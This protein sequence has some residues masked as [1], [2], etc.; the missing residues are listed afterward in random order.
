MYLISWASELGKPEDATA[1]AVRAGLDVSDYRGWPRFCRADDDDHP[2]TMAARALRR[3]LDS[4]GVKA[5]E[6]GAVIYTG[7]SRDYPASWSVATEVVQLIGGSCIG[8]D[9]TFGCLGLLIG[10]DLARAWL[11]RARLVAVVTAERWA[12]TVDRGAAENV[13]IWAHADGAAAVVCSSEG[14]RLRLLDTEY[15]ARPEM[16]GTVFIK[17]GG[18]RYPTPPP[19][20]SPHTRQLR[21][22]RLGDLFAKYTESLERVVRTVVRR[23][24]AADFGLVCN[25]ISP[26]VVRELERRVLDGRGAIPRTGD[27][28]GHV[29]GADLVLGIEA[30]ESAGALAG[31]LVV[32]SSSPYSYAAAALRVV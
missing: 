4:A 5:S 3:A 18:T 2:S 12:Y 7:V 1:Q 30:L 9:I 24:G 32:A 29:G 25:Q 13:A 14:G 8:L 19:S 22:E 23:S 21:S 16:N 11:G 26:M 10:I 28:F 6:L 20:E 15:E 31:D 27:N 17:Y